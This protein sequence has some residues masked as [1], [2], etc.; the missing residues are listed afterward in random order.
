M[1]LGLVHTYVLD[2]V[3]SRDTVVSRDEFTT[4]MYSVVKPDRIFTRIGELR[5]SVIIKSQYRLNR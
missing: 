5:A 1:Y 4:H 3:Q 2:L